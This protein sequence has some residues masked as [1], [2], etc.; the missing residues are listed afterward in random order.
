[1]LNSI[2]PTSWEFFLTHGKPVII[3]LISELEDCGGCL[4]SNLVKLRRV[5]H[6]PTF[7][8]AFSGYFKTWRCSIILPN[9]IMYPPQGRIKPKMPT[10]PGLQPCFSSPS[11][12]EAPFALC[13]FRIHINQTVA[14]IV[15]GRGKN[16]LTNVPQMIGSVRTYL[17]VMKREANQF[18]CS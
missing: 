3:F 18:L 16:N 2:N 4:K 5:V 13:F 14:T 15:I 7:A 8:R 10:S 11:R 12:H 6:M 1:M 17:T 9:L